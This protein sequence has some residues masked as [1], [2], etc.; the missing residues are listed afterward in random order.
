MD[1]Y[2][3]GG[4][5]RIGVEGE[6]VVRDARS[7]P[8]CE[9]TEVVSCAWP[10]CET[11]ECTTQTREFGPGDSLDRGVTG[12]VG[13]FDRNSSVAFNEALKKQLISI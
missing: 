10:G 4:S 2:I 3:P 9:V 5:F 7:C 13:G 6:D 12:G 8:G 11:G 1:S